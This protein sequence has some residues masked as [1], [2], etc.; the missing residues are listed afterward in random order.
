MDF[1]SRFYLFVFSKTL[2]LFHYSSTNE[3]DH[4][5]I[6]KR[7]TSVEPSRGIQG[8]IILDRGS[9]CDRHRRVNH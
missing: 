4:S 2:Q 9:R 8:K 6:R 1:S 3:D 7:S 5:L